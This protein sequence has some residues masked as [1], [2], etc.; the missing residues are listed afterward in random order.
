MPGDA[1]PA[2]ETTAAFSASPRKRGSHRWPLGCDGS[3]VL[4]AGKEQ[5]AGARGVKASSTSVDAPPPAA[6]SAPW[7]RSSLPT[8]VKQCANCHIRQCKIHPLQDHGAASAKLTSRAKDSTLDKMYDALVAPQISK[9]RADLE[10]RDGGADDAYRDSLRKD[11]EKSAKRKR[12]DVGDDALALGASG[13]NGNV[14]HFMAARGDGSGDDSDDDAGRRK[15]RKRM[16]KELKKVKKEAKKLK[17]KRKKKDKKKKDKRKKDAKGDAS[18]DDDDDKKKKDAKGDASSDDDASEARADSR[19]REDGEASSSDDDDGE[20]RP[21]VELPAILASS[22][23][24]S[25]GAA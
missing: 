20:G 16:K 12:R 19:R 7:Q 4:S 22:D 23:S 2:R 13:L 24:S 11:R 10:A 21:P 1:E 6:M 9:Y 14:V 17:K 5:L 15:D 25:D 8:T 18:S 3:N